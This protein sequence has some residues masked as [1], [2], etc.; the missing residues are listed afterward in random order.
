MVAVACGLGPLVATSLA[1]AATG[2][3]LAVTAPKTV[4][5][6]G[7]PNSREPSGESP[8]GP[9]ALAG[10]HLTY[11]QEFAGKALPSG[12][13]KFDGQPSGDPTAQFARN[14]V[15]I[16]G[17]IVRL[18]AYRDP[19]YKGAWAT[20][21]MCQ[22]GVGHTY[23]A[24]FVRSRIT[25]PGPDDSEMLWPV[26]HTWPPEVDFNESGY[27]TTKT[28]WTVHYGH[29]H[30][31]VQTTHNFD[32]TKWHTWG[33]IWRARSLNFLVDGRSWGTMTTVSRVPHQAMT[34]DIQQQ[35]W[36]GT[37]FS[38]C[39]HSQVSLQV[40]WVAEYRAN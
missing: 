29:G 7:V 39:P 19:A 17:G 20:G 21:G 27:P 12:W 31:I 15:R 4:Y 33:V 3:S 24:Y 28:S 8:P 9:N 30:A 13:G 26:A 35:T 36:C 40:D 5:P 6:A 2:G 25:G 10:Y 37:S 32:M 11:Q 23:G 14:H 1:N 22:C 34:L 38:A 18:I 16:G